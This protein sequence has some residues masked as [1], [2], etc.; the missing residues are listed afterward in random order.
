MKISSIVGGLLLM[1]AG[2]L[3]LAQTPSTST[4]TLTVN[5]KSMTLAHA[6]ALQLR[7]WDMGPDGKLVEISVVDVFL[8]DVPVDDP[9]DDFDLGVR[10]KGG[11]LHGVRMRLNPKG[12]V[13]SAR[14]F[15]NAFQEGVDNVFPDH[16]QLKLKQFDGKGVG[17][18]VEVK[19]AD[20]M[21]GNAYK[22]VATFSAPI[23][24]EPKP[25]VEGPAAAETAPAKAVQ[26]FVRSVLAKDKPGLE[27]ILRKEFVEMLENPEQADAV[28]GMLDQF[29]PVEETRQMKIVRVFDFGDRAWVE[30]TTKRQSESGGEPTDVTYRIRVIRVNNDWKV[31]PM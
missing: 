16:V 29:Y 17:G 11:K 30:G 20:D 12:Q 13:L 6:T 8:S 25:T 18:K 2:T 15:D 10:G 1:A 3:A 19:E 24:G 4:G 5:K 26:E 27:R 7:D 23:L 31:Q 14:V 22:F 21:R 28:M 9:E